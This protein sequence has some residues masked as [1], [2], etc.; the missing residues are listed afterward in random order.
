MDKPIICI[1]KQTGETIKDWEIKWCGFVQNED[2]LRM[3]ANVK[4]RTIDESNFGIYEELEPIVSSPT[5]LAG[6][7]MLDEKRKFTKVYQLS[8]PT[9]SKDSFYKIWIHIER[10]IEM[11]T[12]IILQRHKGNKVTPIREIIDWIKFTNLSKTTTYSFIKE[13]VRSQYIAPFGAKPDQLWVINP[14][15]CWNGNLIPKCI[16]EL[17]EWLT[18]K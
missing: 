4:G 12:G 1:N 13:C 11:N 9:F 6:M 17:F 18:I 8:E 7:I 3:R 14:K 10:S 5:D 16:L 2:K 15:F